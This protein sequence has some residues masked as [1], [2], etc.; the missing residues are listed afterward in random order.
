[1]GHWSL[2]RDPVLLVLF[3]LNFGIWVAIW[4]GLV[5]RDKGVDIHTPSDQGSRIRIGI[6]LWSKEI[7][8]AS[9]Q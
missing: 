3:W 2:A 8:P 9:L 4:V 6:S 5:V 1:M 7:E